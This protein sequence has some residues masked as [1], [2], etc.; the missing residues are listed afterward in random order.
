MS[1]PDE[2]EGLPSASGYERLAAC[3]GSWQLERQF[4]DNGPPDPVAERG[5]RIHRAFETGDTSNLSSDELDDYQQGLKHADMLLAQWQRDFNI[6]AV[7]E[8]PRE[9]RL[10]LHQ[11][12]TLDPLGSGKMDRW[13]RS[14][15]RALII[16]FKTG[17]AGYVPPSPRNPQMRFYA[18]C[19]WKELDIPNIRVCIDRAKSRVGSNDYADYTLSDLQY[20]EQLLLMHLW[21]AKEPDAPRYPG[22]HCHF[23][24]GKSGCPQAAAVAL[25]PSVITHSQGMVALKPELAVGSLTDEDLRKIWCADTLIR[26]ILDAVDARLKTFPKDRLAALGLELPEK[27][28]RL[29]PITDPKGAIEVLRMIHGMPEGDLWAAI[30]LSKTPIEKFI[31]E[32]KHL[33]EKGAKGWIEEAL[34]EFITKKNAEPSLRRLKE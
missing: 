7:E 16:D 23:C 17:W 3:P 33:S 27:G 28:R 19:V 4:S 5:N 30:T 26:K 2:R 32:S 25:L 14:R 9:S 34:A 8:L 22:P 10:W 12:Q 11:P 13:Y 20:A 6:E 21:A 18:L 31:R 24:K 15:D 29:D 1:T